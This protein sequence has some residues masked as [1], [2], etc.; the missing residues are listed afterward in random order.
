MK[1]GD[2]N[3]NV[4]NATKK[5]M[6][7]QMKNVRDIPTSQGASNNAG[8]PNSQNDDVFDAL[9][10]SDGNIEELLG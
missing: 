6:L 3:K 2:V 4:A 9:L 7:T 10:N 8:K 1:Q 5:D